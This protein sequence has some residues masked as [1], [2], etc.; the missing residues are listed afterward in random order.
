MAES[1]VELVSAPN[2]HEIEKL[3]ALTKD[4][5]QKLT[6][7]PPEEPDRKVSSSVILVGE[8]R[9]PVTRSRGK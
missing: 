2:L 8:D 6:G 4:Q 3:P 9:P 7:L 1:E 5:N